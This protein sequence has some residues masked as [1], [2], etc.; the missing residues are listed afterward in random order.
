[1]MIAQLM[2]ASS[3]SVELLR[4][5]VESHI[6]ERN[7]YWTK[8]PTMETKGKTPEAK[9]LGINELFYDWKHGHAPPPSAALRESSNCLW[10]KERAEKHTSPISS[11]VLG[12]NEN[13][14]KLLKP[15][16]KV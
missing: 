8:F 9:I 13:K 12:I 4:N 11:S 2:P 5:M 3:N 14:E 7:K 15:S 16:K 10:W 6:L 1:M